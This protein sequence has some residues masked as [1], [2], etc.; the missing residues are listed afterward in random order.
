MK[1]PT[2]D[3]FVGLGYVPQGMHRLGSD[4]HILVRGRP[5]RARICRRPFYKS[6][7]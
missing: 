1:S 3:K 4:I 5:R 6:R 7:R 2:L